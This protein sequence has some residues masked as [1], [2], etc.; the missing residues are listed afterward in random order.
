MGLSAT[1]RTSLAGLLAKTEMTEAAWD[2]L[3]TRGLTEASVSMFRL[4]G[5]SGEVSGEWARFNGMLAIPYLSGLGEPVAVKFR[6]LDGGSPKYDGPA[7]QGTRL[8]NVS[9]CLSDGDVIVV[10]EGEIDAMTLHA[11][12]GIPAVGVP[13][14]KAWKK[15]HK[16]C[17][18]GFNDVVILTDNDAKDDGSNPG[19]G[20]AVDIKG[21]LPSSRIV[22]LPEGE[23]VNSFFVKHGAEAVREL[24]GV[25]L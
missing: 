17:L 14:V 13:G 11:E 2:Y 18:D 7:G 1:S 5:V 21:Q 19:L 23:D 16:R 22:R 3:H 20:L 9:A 10:T 15:H 6:R 12:C 25:S 4:G 24:V 8:F